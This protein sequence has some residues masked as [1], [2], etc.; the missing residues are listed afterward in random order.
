MLF[1][2]VWIL[3]G[4]ALLTVGSVAMYCPDLAQMVIGDLED[5]ITFPMDIFR[6]T[7]RTYS[8]AVEVIVMIIIIG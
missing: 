8:L 6:F 7:R 3:I 1:L 4:R 2:D 5:L